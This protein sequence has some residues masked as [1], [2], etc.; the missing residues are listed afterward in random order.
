MQCEKTCEML[1][2]RAYEIESWAEDHFIDSNGVVYSYLDKQSGNPIT[3]SFFTEADNPFTVN[4]Y[5]AS[6]LLGYENCGMTTGAYLQAQL[7]R[8]AVEKDPEVLERARRSYAAL[9]YIYRIGA[10]LEE[11][12][13]PKIYGNQF[14]PQTSTDQVLYAMMAMDHYC[15]YA[16][17][18]EKSDIGYMIASMVRFWM[19]RNYRYLYFSIE[20]M[21][22]PLGRF[23]P[24]LLMA[25]YHS[26][27]NLFQDEYNRLTQM[28][29]NQFPVEEQL[30]PKLSGEV[31]PIAYEKKMNAW[32]VAHRADAVT[33]DV[34]ALDYLKSNDGANT[35]SST[36]ANSIRQMWDEGKLTLSPDG[37]MYVQILV[38]MVTQ[39][40]RRPDPCMFTEEIGELDW[41]GFRHLSGARTSWSTMIARAGVQ[42]YRHLQDQEMLPAIVKILSGV[43]LADLTYYDDPDR[44]LP[45]LQHKT[46]FFSG[47]A[48]ANW[49]WAYWQGCHDGILGVSN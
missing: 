15:K 37:K 48:M 3:E 10:R 41:I 40:V 20:N 18:K 43:G 27:D 45:Q 16:D 23:T 6:D 35:Y 26:G 7:F 33:M 42:A 47:D 12:F 25:Y 14:T 5:L 30:R 2:D 11:G 9:K 24:F 4:G 29:V 28:G 1:R 36:W 21:Q 44:F 8:Y 49:L 22:W 39:E 34:M 13:F 31:S 19:K 32:L 17:A 46:R 38:D